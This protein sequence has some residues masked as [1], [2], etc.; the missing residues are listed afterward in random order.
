MIEAQ[1]LS[2]GKLPPHAAA[3]LRPGGHLVTGYSLRPDGFGPGQHDSLA[4]GAGL[5]LRDRWSTWDKAPYAPSDA[6]AV[7]VHR[8]EI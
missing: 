6:Y 3:S 2:I 4:A 1:S 7:A 5:V 8:R